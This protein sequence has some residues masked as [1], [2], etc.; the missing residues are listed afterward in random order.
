[1]PTARTALVLL[2]ACLAMCERVTAQEAWETRY[3]QR[4]EG[5]AP[6]DTRGHYA[7]AR[8]CEQ[9]RRP[10]EA[11]RHYRMVL[12]AE[13]GHARARQCLEALGASPGG[14]PAGGP[15]GTGIPGTPGRHDLTLEGFQGRNG[16]ARYTLWIPE[17]SARGQ[18]LPLAIVASYLAQ[19]GGDPE[20]VLSEW[21]GFEGYVA[22]VLDSGSDYPGFMTRLAETLVAD[23]HV[24]RQSILITDWRSGHQVPILVG[25]RPDLFR[26]GYSDSTWGGTPFPQV[27]TPTS[28]Q[29]GILRDAHVYMKL[30]GEGYKPQDR[31][32]DDADASEVRAYWEALG[33]RDV[34]IER[35]PAA[36]NPSEQPDYSCIMGGGPGARVRQWFEEKMRMEP[37]RLALTTECARREAAVPAGD[38]RALIRFG[39]WCEA[40][41]LT[42]KAIEVYRKIL[43]ID[44]SRTPIRRA[45]ERLTEGS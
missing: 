12:A 31:G 22:V 4:A 36:S 34:V 32:Y 33:V 16:P 42:N 28:E 6:D 20:K 37:R 8:W 39:N 10:E 2:T 3:A 40:Q 38:V 41:G 11:A 25:R 30:T 15:G 29:R 18:P 43:D 21:T 44:P 14:A 9:C 24:D 23:G 27:P 26:Y 19:S 1:M 5:L 13:P 35:Y 17:A 7:L 45:L